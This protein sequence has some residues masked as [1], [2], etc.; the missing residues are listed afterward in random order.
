MLKRVLKPD[1]THLMAPDE[2]YC[3]VIYERQWN[4][5]NVFDLSIEIF[6]N[7][8]IRFQKTYSKITPKKE[9][10]IIQ[11]VLGNGWE[12]IFIQNYDD[13]MIRCQKRPRS[14]ALAHKHLPV[15]SGMGSSL[16]RQVILAGVGVGAIALL[17]PWISG[18]FSQ[19]TPIA[20]A[21]T[22]ATP[23]DSTL[24]S[25]LDNSDSNEAAPTTDTTVDH[26][27]NSGHLTENVPNAEENQN[28]DGEAS[29]NDM[30]GDAARENQVNDDQTNDAVNGNETNGSDPN[31]DATNGEVNAAEGIRNEAN[32]DGV[33]GDE[34]NDPF[35]W[36]VRLAQEAVLGGE[37]AET[38]EEWEALAERWQEAADLMADVPV[39]DERYA[40]AQDRIE[41]YEN[42]RDITLSEAQKA[43]ANNN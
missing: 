39:D 20:D 29:G 24:N 22:E 8:G 2:E 10:D 5:P 7:G 13:W 35:V 1:D 18:Q 40:I 42:N 21:P 15:S 17:L 43:Q 37:V 41:A 36:A 9:K 16:W 4:A 32:A 34:D 3:R 14:T 6:D 11:T 12:T 33:N 28:P 19:P 31:D 38:P 27:P 23:P 30:N 25:D 26:Q